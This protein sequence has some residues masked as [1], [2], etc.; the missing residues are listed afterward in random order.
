ME[1]HTFKDGRS[2]S[3]WHSLERKES[4]SLQSVVFVVKKIVPPIFTLTHSS[5]EALFCVEEDCPAMTSQSHVCLA[6]TLAPPTNYQF[7]RDPV[8]SCKRATSVVQ[9]QSEAR[10]VNRSR[11]VWREVLRHLILHMLIK[12]Q[13]KTKKIHY[14]QH[15]KWGTNSRSVHFINLLIVSTALKCCGVWL[16]K[17]TNAQVN[18]VTII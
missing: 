16:T 3:S 11:K 1:H 8:F 5:S 14:W 2:G 6:Y 10:P 18:S 9:W 13:R 4:F 17:A 7:C 15:L 12:S